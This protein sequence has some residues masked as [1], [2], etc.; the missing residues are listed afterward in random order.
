M[1][2]L[3]TLL[4]QAK[5]AFACEVLVMAGDI[6]AMRLGADWQRL[7]HPRCTPAD[8]EALVRTLLPPEKN[9]NLWELLA[10]QRELEFEHASSSVGTV[11]CNVHF[12]RGSLVLLICRADDFAKS[13]RAGQ[14]RP[15]SIPAA[16]SAKA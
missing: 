11:H 1:I 12:Q 16:S 5:A 14:S 4:Q 7:A 3:D 9:M 2:P 15:A 6:P 8:V 13:G 10:D